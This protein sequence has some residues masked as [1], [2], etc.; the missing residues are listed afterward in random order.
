VEAVDLG[1]W[2]DLPA[3]LP[4]G[5]TRIRGK[6]STENRKKKG[7]LSKKDSTLFALR[8][9]DRSFIRVF[10]QQGKGLGI[11]KKRDKKLSSKKVACVRFV[12]HVE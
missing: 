6:E 7:S 10:W 2:A 1:D 3:P 12:F 8:K 4:W 11:G 9:T 5:E